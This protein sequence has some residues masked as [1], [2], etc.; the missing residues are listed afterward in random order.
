[1]TQTRS[2]LRAA[3]PRL[4]GQS[5]GDRQLDIVADKLLVPFFAA[6]FFT[7]IA[8]LE[9]AHYFQWLR[10]TPW[11]FVTL[12]IG[13]IAWFAYSWF[14]HRKAL[15]NLRLGQD[16]ERQ[17]G[18]AIEALRANGYSVFHD[19]IADGFNIDH[20]LVGPSGIYAIETK[21]RSKRVGSKDKL[22]FDGQAVALGNGQPDTKAVD[23]AQRQADWL[24]SKLSAMVDRKPLVRP[25]LVYPGWFIEA[26]NG[27]HR[28][29]L[30]LNDNAL[31]TWIRKSPPVLSPDDVAL[32]TNRLHLLSEPRA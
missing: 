16:G 31:V 24:E 17:V 20:V 9:V 10:L 11:L 28:N 22:Y 12:A 2:P 25:V 30:V 19:V 5:I 32:F 1:M 23:Q 13:A 15:I 8:L 7:F 3:L 4:P 6:V 27:A 14:T 21:T 29:I 18:A 26:A